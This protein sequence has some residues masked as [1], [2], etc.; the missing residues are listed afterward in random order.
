[1]S[2]HPQQTADAALILFTRS[3]EA[4]ERAKPL[5][6]APGLGGRLFGHL[7]DRVRALARPLGD[8]DLLISAPTDSICGQ[9]TDLRQ[10]GG[11][12]GEALRDAVAQARARGYRRIVVI[13]NDA[14]ALSSAY[15]RAALR[16]LQGSARR[17]VLGPAR[18]GGFVLLGVNE[19]CSAALE[20]LPW[21]QRRAGAFVHT[22][23]QQA[24]FHVERLPM[25]DDL[26]NH[27]DLT[28]LLRRIGAAPAAWVER[29][30]RWVEGSVKGWV[31]AILP[32]R[33]AAVEV[34]PPRRGPPA[35]V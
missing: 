19:D 33:P 31:Q 5:L 1:M 10:H 18:D 21:G 17:A 25:L 4:E 14:P 9:R 22:T 8:V 23:L 11:D 30:R 2:Q 28:R 26:D 3:A 6:R 35:P 20:G 15:L 16:R 32:P 24:G 13:G 34:R 12:A 27:Q 29:L 7:I